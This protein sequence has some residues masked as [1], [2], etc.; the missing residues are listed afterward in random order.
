MNNFSQDKIRGLI[1]G[2]LIGNALGI[3][4]EFMDKN[5]ISKY[6]PE[7]ITYDNIYQDEHRKNWERGEFSDDGDIF[8]VILKHILDTEDFIIDQQILAK[9]FY[10]W[11]TTGLNINGNIKLP[12]G[13]GSTT[14]RVFSH[15]LFLKNCRIPS[16]LYSNSKANGGVMRTSSIS[17]FPNCIENCMNTCQITHMNNDCI[18]S[19]LFIN[20]LIQEMNI[21][22]ILLKISELG[23]DTKELE[24]YINTTDLTS[25]DLCNSIGYTYK[26]IGC[27]M[28]A[29]NQCNNKCFYEIIHE[30]IREGGD[31]DT[32]CAVA[33]AVLGSIIGY[34]KI[35]KF[36]ID[37]LKHKDYI[38]NFINYIFSKINMK[39]TIPKFGYG[40]KTKVS[41]TEKDVNKQK[42]YTIDRNAVKLIYRYTVASTEI[43]KF[44]LEL[45]EID[46]LIK[47]A[48]RLKKNYSLYAMVNPDYTIT[49]GGEVKYT[50][51]QIGDT[52]TLDKIISTTA[53]KSYPLTPFNKQ[54]VTMRNFEEEDIKHFVR[55]N[56]YWN[57]DIRK[58][59][60]NDAELQEA[61]DK[62][63]HYLI[64]KFP[65][66]FEDNNDSS[67]DEIEN[68]IGEKTSLTK[69]ATVLSQKYLENYCCCC[70]LK[71]KSNKNR[72]TKLIIYPFSQYPDQKEVIFSSDAKFKLLD[73]SRNTY[74]V[75]TNPFSYY[76]QDDVNT[77]KIGNE[78]YIQFHPLPKDKKY[79]IQKI[80][81]YTVQEL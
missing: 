22:D 9:R 57:S 28:Y 37:G 47:G 31:A 68:M 26:P 7:N 40:A 16:L 20:L 64:I 53:D 35:D 6:Y 58:Y 10:E 2:Q 76:E 73:I 39:N 19:C 36:L 5:D 70:L 52:F 60:M 50:D 3:A 71:I 12:H 54:L 75:F 45:A 8:L 25:L 61:Y 51:L 38:E 67:I 72:R 48:P 80:S 44:P 42:K 34:E 13:V 55:N 56:V 78:E 4:T 27:A 79:R 14:R 43:R 15:P 11:Y 32:N 21:P 69:I 59:V 49:S 63:N 24:K 46:S 41:L 23:F 1:Y 30:I 18:I 77:L 74:G 66:I 33:G 29:I 62:I 65:E 81:V 17:L